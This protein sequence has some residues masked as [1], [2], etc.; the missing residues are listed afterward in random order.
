MM[1][2]PKG[3]ETQKGTWIGGRRSGDNRPTALISCPN[4]GQFMSLSQHT[5]AENGEVTPSLV[6]PH[7]GCDFHEHITLEN[8]KN[9]T[10]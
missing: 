5:I 10:A 3:D 1:L 7:Y 9:D 6:C 4:C 2:I 8:W